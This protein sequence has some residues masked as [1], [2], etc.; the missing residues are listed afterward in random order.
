MEAIQTNEVGGLT[1]GIEIEIHVPV[2]K[3]PESDPIEK[4]VDFPSD[5]WYKKT[6][7]FYSPEDGR[8]IPVVRDDVMTS[9]GARQAVWDMLLVL[10]K[11]VIE[12]PN[13][14]STDPDIEVVTA[15]NEHP[16]KTFEPKHGAQEATTST[17][18][19]GVDPSHNT[20]GDFVDGHYEV[21]NTWTVCKDESGCWYEKADGELFLTGKLPPI[22]PPGY[23]WFSIEIKSKVYKDLD[24]M[25]EDLQKVCDRIRS[26]FLVSINC[27]RGYNRTSTHVH[28]G[29]SG[30]WNPNQEDL[31]F[32]LV[33]VK[34]MATA[35]CILE[36]KLMKMHAPWKADNHKYAALLKGYTHLGE[37]L[38]PDEKFAGSSLPIDPYPSQ[39][40]TAVYAKSSFTLNSRQLNEIQSYLCMDTRNRPHEAAIHMIWGADDLMHL[41]WLLSCRE[42]LRRGAFALHGLVPTKKN[43]I[44]SRHLNTIEFRHMHGSMD[45]EDIMN[46][47]RIIEKIVS[48]SASSSDKDYVTLLDGIEP[49]GRGSIGDVAQAL[50]LRLA[51]KSEEQ[52]AKETLLPEVPKG[53]DERKKWTQLG[54]IM[55]LSKNC[56]P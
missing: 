34:K 56:E 44:K 4:A 37:F 49:D 31:P 43:V 14:D 12:T 54:P 7:L 42:G 30:N 9:K 11:A 2:L 35:M 13:C 50:G 27:G 47:I 53:N 23:S 16:T 41:A 51:I 21:Y 33:A 5:D 52:I 22:G 48:I 32:N 17:L 46:W 29:R 6:C 55:F 39:E 28:V 8:K 15:E 3:A 25:Q 20:L 24:A 19:K 40:N 45:A 1:F 38:N 36:S 26:R 18:G 10:F